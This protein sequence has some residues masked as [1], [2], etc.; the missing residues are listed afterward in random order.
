VG[1]VPTEKLGPVFS[2]HVRLL[3][4]LVTE[5]RVLTREMDFYIKTSMLCTRRSDWVEN[6]QYALVTT[7]VIVNVV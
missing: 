3:P 2:P 6:P 1:I 5:Q 7:V 4:C